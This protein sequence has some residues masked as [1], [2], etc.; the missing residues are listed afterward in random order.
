MLSVNYRLDSW[1]IRYQLNFLCVLGY[2][3]SCSCM[4]HDIR[5]FHIKY[6]SEKRQLVGCFFDDLGRGF[7]GAVSR[8]GFDSD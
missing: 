8:F 2:G 3:Q 6:S 7:S 4:I 1:S 5:S